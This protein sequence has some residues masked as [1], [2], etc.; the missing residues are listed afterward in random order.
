MNSQRTVH[1]I[2]G[3]PHCLVDGFRHSLVQAV[4][5]REQRCYFLT[6]YHSDHYAGLRASWKEGVIYCSSTTAKLLINVMGV[7]AAVVRAVEL[8]ETISIP[9][10]KVT[11]LDANHCPGAV[12]L[13]FKVSPSG[14]AYLHTGD[15]RYHPRMRSYPSLQGVLLDRVYLDTTYAH[16]RHDFMDQEQAVEAI[17]S[18]ARCFLSDGQGLL[19]VGAYGLGKERVLFALLQALRLPMYADE[20]RLLVLRQVPGGEE[21]LR[22]GLLTACPQR[23]RIHIVSMGLAGSVW[24]NGGKGVLRPNYSKLTAKLAAVNEL[25]AA[26]GLAPLSKLLAV[27]PTGW[28][29]GSAVQQQ[30]QGV[31]AVQAVPYSEHSACRELVDWVAFLRPREVI[32]T[33]YADDKQRDSMLALFSSKLDRMAGLR[34]F[35]SSFLPKPK[36]L[37]VDLTGDD[38]HDHDDRMTVRSQTCPATPSAGASASAHLMVGDGDSSALA[39]GKRRRTTSTCNSSSSG[40]SS[41]ISSWVCEHCTFVN[42]AAGSPAAA[43]RGG[44]SSSSCVLQQQQPYKAAARGDDCDRRMT[45]ITSTYTCSSSHFLFCKSGNLGIWV[46]VFFALKVFFRL[47]SPIALLDCNHGQSTRIMAAREGRKQAEELDNSLI[48]GPSE[49][50]IV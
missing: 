18:S 33:V 32:P 14:L 47:P 27:I 26:E 44:V 28:A 41:S 23:A 49:D 22:G 35:V 2:P 1:A 40:I 50:E 19:T 37:L 42:V 24:G 13:L 38:D 16:P 45:L 7:S 21:A 11:F 9:G 39:L 30:A 31:Y 3:L 15:M 6:H 5:V 48:G 36:E 8:D 10:A 17:V 46:K 20:A 12:M 25:R 34:H 4:P 29:H 43:A